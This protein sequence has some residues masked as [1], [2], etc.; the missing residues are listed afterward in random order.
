MSGPAK[1]GAALSTAAAA[2]TLPI[3]PMFGICAS[4]AAA[5]QWLLDNDPDA[6]GLTA[7][8][9]DELK[10]TTTDMKQSMQ[11]NV[12][13]LI[14]DKLWHEPG[15]QVFF[16]DHH[17]QMITGMDDMEK[18]LGGASDSF[19]SVKKLLENIGWF[20]LAA[21]GFF[22][23]V[24]TYL[25]ATTFINPAAQVQGGAQG[26]QRLSTVRTVLEKWKSFLQK[27]QDL[28]RKLIGRLKKN[29]PAKPTPKAA[30]AAANAAKHAKPSK[31]GGMRK[32]GG[33]IMLPGMVGMGG[34]SYVS[35]EFGGE[36]QQM[37]QTT[38]TNVQW[39]GP[40]DDKT[41][42]KDGDKPSDDST[43]A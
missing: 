3:V 32:V 16:Q 4:L 38:A 37:G 26:S 28:L 6:V 14:P 24:G 30:K 25:L 40:H 9:F 13:K 19:Q 41:T 31:F 22:M 7:A 20:S 33:K 23:A 36:A 27:L 12:P 42:S 21:G 11:E 35:S 15:S 2:M 10:K 8:D 17:E 18:M 5:A 29:F 43:P 39:P 34:Y 1:T